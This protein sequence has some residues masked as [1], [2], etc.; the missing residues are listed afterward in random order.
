MIGFSTIETVGLV[1]LIHSD[2]DVPFAKKA[3]QPFTWIR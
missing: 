1:V 3:R 2:M